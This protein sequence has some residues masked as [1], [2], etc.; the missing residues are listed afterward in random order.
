MPSGTTYWKCTQRS[1][2]RNS[3]AT[4]KTV[5]GTGTLPSSSGSRSLP[6][7]RQLH[8]HH[9]QHP[10]YIVGDFVFIPSIY[11][12]A[13]RWFLAAYIREM[14][15]RLPALL[16]ASTSIYGSIIKID[17]TKKVCK[18]LQGAA[19][20]TASW[21]TNMSN[22]RGEVL[23]SILTESEGERALQP[24]ATGLMRRYQQ[25]GVDPPT[26]L[27]TDKDCCSRSGASKYQ[28]HMTNRAGCI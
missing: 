2:F 15:S 27:Y 18:K 5:G 1:G 21:A 26:L 19:A 3:C 9:S 14:W 17:S 28:V 7:E 12:H 16:A 20:Q 10:G 11:L 23:I 6:T 25:A 22:E 24:M 4:S 8:S 13:C